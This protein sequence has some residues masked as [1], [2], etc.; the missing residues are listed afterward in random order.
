MW[1]LAAEN[2][3]DFH[4]LAVQHHRWGVA[5]SHVGG[6]ATDC[7]VIE[8]RASIVLIGEVNSEQRVEIPRNALHRLA[9]LADVADQRGVRRYLGP[10][11][12]VECVGSLVQVA[13]AA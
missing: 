12:D 13:A 8:W 2:R 11:G 9:G 5:G 4:R 7:F 6:K 10:P 1:P 3:I